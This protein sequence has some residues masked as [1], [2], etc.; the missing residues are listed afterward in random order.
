MLG[1]VRDITGLREGLRCRGSLELGQQKG[2]NL[3]MSHREGP[4]GR[5]TW[6]ELT[7]GQE[8]VASGAS[9]K[10]QHPLP[11]VLQPLQV[12]ADAA[13]CAVWLILLTASHWT[14]RHNCIERSWHTMG[15]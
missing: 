7:E 11:L 4:A 9:H 13:A 6:T 3:G 2:G 1:A 5:N 10:A 15:S 8:A 14:S 12:R